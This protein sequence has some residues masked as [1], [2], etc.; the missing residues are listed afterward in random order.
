MGGR[1]NGDRTKFYARFPSVQRLS[2]S[3]LVLGL[4]YPYR[5]QKVMFDSLVVPVDGTDQTDVLLDYAVGQA[6]TWDATLHLV[7][8]VDRPQVLGAD[9]HREEVSRGLEER[10]RR[11]AGRAQT[12]AGRAGV[13][14]TITVER[15]LAHREILDHA[16]AHDADLIVLGPV[17]ADG[18]AS[19]VNTGRV[20]SR[21]VEE[22][23][24]PVLVTD[25][26]GGDVSSPRGTDVRGSALLAE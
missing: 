18:G 23:T 5:E 3:N 20:T 26:A 17:G 2:E 13:E 22:S 8:V 6:R 1:F 25:E 14:T 15:G 9:E 19:A 21:V 16:A 7:A 11:A 24:R 12:K 10:A 4:K